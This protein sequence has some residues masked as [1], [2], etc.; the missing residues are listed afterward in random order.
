[1]ILLLLHKHVF[2]STPTKRTNDSQIHRARIHDFEDRTEVRAGLHIHPFGL[3]N[4]R[5]EGVTLGYGQRDV[6]VPS[7]QLLNTIW[8]AHRRRMCMWLAWSFRSCFGRVSILS[9]QGS[10]T[11]QGG[12]NVVGLHGQVMWLVVMWFADTWLLARINI[13]DARS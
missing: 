1:M 7:F 2:L 8:V 3:E 11:C 12:T 5:A 9:A 4:L 6:R 10:S 13:V